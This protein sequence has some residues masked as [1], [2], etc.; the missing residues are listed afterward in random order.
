MLWIIIPLVM[1]VIAFIAGYR[2]TALGLLVASAIAGASI[3]LLTEQ[4]QQ[5]AETRLSAS[6]ISLENVTVRHTFDASYELTGRLKNAS[7]IYQVFGITLNV[8][9]RDCRTGDASQCVAAGEAEA[10]AAVTVP[11]GESR[12]FTATMYLGKGHGRP[13]GRLAWD[14]EIASVIAKRP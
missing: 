14:Y 10:R 4:T 7:A 9:L 6:E 8:K 3:Y 11:P 12:D 13:K 1:A 2:R 5:R